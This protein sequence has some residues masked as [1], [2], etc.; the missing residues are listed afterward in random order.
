[1][2]FKN[3][4][5]L[6]DPKFR[7]D[8]FYKDIAKVN[9]LESLSPNWKG[10]DFYPP[11]PQFCADEKDC[12][13][14]KWPSRNKG[15]KG[16][17]TLL[18]DPWCI[19][20]CVGF[21]WTLKNALKG[22]V[23]LMGIPDSGDSTYARAYIDG[24]LSRKSLFY[25]VSVTSRPGGNR[26]K[27][28]IGFVFRQAVSIS[29]ST[30]ENG[31]IISALPQRLDRFVGTRWDESP[32]EWAAGLIKVALGFETIKISSKSFEFEFSNKDEADI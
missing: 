15:F 22:R 2:Q 9:A 3:I 23:V 26:A 29:R 30:D 12:L 28:R 21:A 25:E 31:E 27:V 18:T 32:D 10:K 16:H 14:I 11:V 24:G 8:S 5:E 20:S 13:K 4:T 6:S 7:D 17:Y 1:M 19:S